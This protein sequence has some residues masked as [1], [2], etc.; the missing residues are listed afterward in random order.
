VEFERL[1]GVGWFEVVGMNGGRF[2]GGF[3]V[4]RSGGNVVKMCG[5]KWIVV[6]GLNGC[7]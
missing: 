2:E 1:A 4:G 6:Y 3:V 5:R 7:F